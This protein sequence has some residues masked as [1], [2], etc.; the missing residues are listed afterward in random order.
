MET[1]RVHVRLK[2]HVDI[3]FSSIYGNWSLTDY[4]YSSQEVCNKLRLSNLLLSR[5]CSSC[6][7]EQSGNGRYNI[8]VLYFQ[9]IAW[10]FW[11]YSMV[12][13]YFQ[14]IEWYFYDI[15]IFHY[16][17]YIFK[18]IVIFVYFWSDFLHVYCFSR[19]EIGLCFKYSK[20]QL[21]L[22]GYCK[23]YDS[24]WMYSKQALDILKAYVKK[25]PVMFQRL[26]ANPD[27]NIFNED[28]LFPSD[29]GWEITW[30]HLM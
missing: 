4:Y 11:K 19:K 22:P 7:C 14:Y 29:S 13:L 28:E 9:N 25:F 27:E 24:I 12:F 10:Y 5:I 3:D 15:Y 20:R 6:S 21:E 26:N 8:F 17:H 2:P 1:D 16:F 18:F 30:C 23:L